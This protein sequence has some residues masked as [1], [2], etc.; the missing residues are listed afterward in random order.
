MSLGSPARSA[1]STAVAASAGAV[2]TLAAF[3][4]VFAAFVLAPVVLLAVALPLY[5]AVRPRRQQAAAT[6]QASG[7][8]AR[9]ARHEFGSGAR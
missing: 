9:A 4:V 1:G 8:P 7:A 5:V 2:L 3:L 6:G